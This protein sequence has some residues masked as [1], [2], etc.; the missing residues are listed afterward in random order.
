MSSGVIQLR[1]P[2]QTGRSPGARPPDCRSAGFDTVNTSLKCL[3]YLDYTNMAHVFTLFIPSAQPRGNSPNLLG[4]CSIK[5]PLYHYHLIKGSESPLL[6]GKKAELSPASEHSPLLMMLFPQKCLFSGE[7]FQTID[8]AEHSCSV[9]GRGSGPGSGQL[10]SRMHF[11]A[12][13]GLRSAG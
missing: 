5:F 6:P 7:S 2:P 3:L 4:I 9:S 1:A 13:E 12:P 11:Q 10:R 8:S